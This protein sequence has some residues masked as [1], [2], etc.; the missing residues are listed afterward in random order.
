MFLK[1]QI[2]DH[3]VVTPREISYEGL[4]VV[5]FS[6]YTIFVYD[7]FPDEQAEIKIIKAQSKIAFARVVKFIKTSKDR[8]NTFESHNLDSAPLINLSYDKQIEFK[9][10]YLQKL[11]TWNLD[12]DKSVIHNFISSPKIY[13]YR[14][15]IRYKL[16]LY[17][18][19]LALFETI[20]KT[21]QL[22]LAQN[23]ILVDNN[24]IQ[25]IKELTK[26][27]SDFF[28]KNQQEYKL[29]Y[30]KEITGRINFEN[31]VTILLEIEPLFDLPQKLINQI[32]KNENLKKLI[33]LVILKNKKTAKVIS[34]KQFQMQLLDKRFIIDPLSFFQVNIEV[35]SKIFEL[36][37]T[38]KQEEKLILDLFCGS[39]VIGQIAAQNEEILG[40]DIDLNA[41]DRAKQNAKLNKF[42]NAKYYTGDVFKTIANLKVDCSNSFLILDPPRAGLGEKLVNWI[43]DQKFK[44]LIYISCDPRTMTRDLK[45]LEKS[46]Y[47]IT[48]VQGFDMFPNTSHI[49]TLV[50]IEII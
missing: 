44:K 45:Q 6:N 41:I 23:F 15:K 40:I 24:L 16:N 21:N 22:K 20:A 2:N 26:Q 3:L 32:I 12:I 13:N 33:E 8:I 27:I 47:K 1:P 46:N 34:K 14:N 18:Q 28:T 35:A 9:Q 29:K 50:I 39:G 43:I 30:F 4:G 17:N 49:E 48:Y 11:L 38:F 19:E 42:T 31:Q 36:A 10:N 25:I 37:L 5:K 7:L